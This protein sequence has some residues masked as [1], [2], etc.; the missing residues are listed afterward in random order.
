MS[1]NLE[2][3][4]ATFH[5]YEGHGKRAKRSDGDNK[6]PSREK[7]IAVTLDLTDKRYRAILDE[8]WVGSELLVKAMSGADSAAQD[9]VSHRK[10][11]ELRVRVMEVDGKTEVFSIATARALGRPTLRVLPGGAKVLMSMRFV[12]PISRDKLPTLDDHCEADVLID[13]GAVQTTVDDHIRDRQAEA[14]DDDSGKPPISR[15]TKKTPKSGKTTSLAVN[16]P[17]N[18]T[19]VAAEGDGEQN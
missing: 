4:P 2:R 8:A 1:F 3:V 17:L 18:L 5:S 13:V 16:E 6:A 11:P 14:D 12:G 7:K 15:R 10:L 9:I 19:L